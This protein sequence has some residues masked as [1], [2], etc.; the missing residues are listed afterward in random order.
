MRTA[1]DKEQRLQPAPQAVLAAMMLLETEPTAQVALVPMRLPGM[2]PSLWTPE[3]P[4]VT[5]PGVVMP[6][7]TAADAT[8]APGWCS[9]QAV[10]EQRSPATTRV[11]RSR[12][13]SAPALRAVGF[14]QSELAPVLSGLQG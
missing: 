3:Q 5:V 13:C 7:S 12:A 2:T 14:T 10:R 8:A 4:V 9:S 11:C 1:R 6:T